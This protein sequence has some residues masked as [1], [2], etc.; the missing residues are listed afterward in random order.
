[1]SGSHND[2]NVLDHFPVFNGIVNGQLPLVNYVVNGHHYRMGYYLF[3]GI[4]P[5]WVT[6]MQTI[7]HP[8]TEKK[9]CLLSNKRHAGKMWNKLW[10]E[11]H[12]NVGRWTPPPND[13]ISIPT[14]SRCP[15]VLIAH[16]FSCQFQIRNRETNTQ[17]RND[18]MENLWNRYGDE[19]V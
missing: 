8:T 14:L 5:K 3:D 12:A 19:D 17:L 1:M 2:I 15:S 7:P 18:L 9:N 16:I 6:L 13:A 10:D 11:R 4:Y